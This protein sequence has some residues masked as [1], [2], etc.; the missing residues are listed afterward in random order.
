MGTHYTMHLNREEFDHIFDMQTLEN[1]RRWAKRD[2]ELLKDQIATS[3]EYVESISRQMELVSSIETEPQVYIQRTHYDKVKFY[4]GVKHVPKVEF[5]SFNRDLYIRATDTEIFEGKQRHA[6]IAYA[7]SLAEK[8]DCDIRR[9]GF[10][11]KD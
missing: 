6:A 9:Q 4:V 1:H 2:I 3:E 11:K 5:E 10:P 8:Y 7:E